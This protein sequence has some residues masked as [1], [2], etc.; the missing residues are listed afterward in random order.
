MQIAC[1][2]TPAN[3]FHILRR[4]MNRQFRKRK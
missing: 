1:M 3:L 4:Q 2:T